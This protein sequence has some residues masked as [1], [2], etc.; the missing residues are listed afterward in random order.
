MRRPPPPTLTP[1]AVACLCALGALGGAARAAPD[2]FTLENRSELVNHHVSGAGAASSF[3][4]RGSHLL[5]ET[6]LFH[7]ARLGSGWQSQ[8]GLMVRYTD[9]PQFSPEKFSLQQFEWR[10]NDQRNDLVVGDYFANLSSYAMSKSLKGLG[11]QRNFGSDQHYLRAVVG[12]FDGQWGFLLRPGHLTDEPMDRHGAGLRY[13]AQNGP[14]TWG[15]NLALAADR[16]GD[17]RRRAG[18]SAWKQALPSLDWEYRLDALTVAGEHAWSRTT[19]QAAAGTETRSHGLANKLSVRAMVGPVN[20]DGRLERV[21]PDFRSLAGAA[22]PDRQR[23]SLRADAQV[24]RLWKLFGVVDYGHNN[25][26]DQ[27]P[28]RTSN[29]SVEAGVTKRRAF[30]RR[31]LTLSASLRQ[32][33]TDL[34]GGG[35]DSTTDRVKLRA[36]DSLGG[37]DLRGDVEFIIDGRAGSPSTRD[38]LYNLGASTRR[39][40]G[41]WTFSPSVDLGLQERENPTGGLDV[42]HTARLGFLAERAPGQVVSLTFDHNESSTPVAGSNTRVGRWVASWETRPTWLKRGALRLEL[43]TNDYRFGNAAGNYR[44]RLGRIVATWPLDVLALKVNP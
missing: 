11:Y 44:E 7:R 3:L 9:S 14:V 6:Q 37:I 24:A 13:Q 21:D 43:A 19:G 17:P 34:H 30:D 18:E 25:L 8:L 29:T 33:S 38:T 23:A 28:Y 31:T 39:E 15:L 40:S 32:R 10:L 1:L 12:S 26:D 35:V 27:L 42:V 5:H 16:Q 22:T 20:L 2:E 41:R 36:T 4:D